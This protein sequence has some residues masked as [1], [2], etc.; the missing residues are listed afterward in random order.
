MT[1]IAS[2]DGDERPLAGEY[3]LGVLDAD[4][5]AQAQARIA[6][7]P[8]FARAV[9]WWVIRLA[10]LAARVAPVEPPGTVWPRIANLVG[11]TETP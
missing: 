10:H 3:V 7:V 5:R 1:D 8:A 2:Y 11:A 9:A 4:E 6:A